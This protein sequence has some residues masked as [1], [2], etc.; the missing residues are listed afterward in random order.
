MAEHQLAELA[1]VL[2][3]PGQWLASCA[4]GHRTVGMSSGHAVEY[5][6]RHVADPQPRDTPEGGDHR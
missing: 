4:C 2:N 1:R 3:A 6:E 5:L